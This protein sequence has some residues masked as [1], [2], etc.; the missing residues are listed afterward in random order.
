MLETVMMLIRAWAEELEA[1]SSFAMDPAALFWMERFHSK[2][3]KYH[4]PEVRQEGKPYVYGTRALKNIPSSI[5]SP[6][7]SK[8]T[9]SSSV[10]S[11]STSN[12]SNGQEETLLGKNIQSFVSEMLGLKELLLQTSDISELADDDHAIHLLVQARLAL[13]KLTNLG[14]KDTNCKSAELQSLEATLLE[15]LEIFDN[16]RKGPKKP[17]KE[18]IPAAE[19][20][21]SSTSF[22]SKNTQPSPKSWTREDISPQ[23]SEMPTDLDDLLSLG[24]S[25]E[26]SG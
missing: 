1:S 25:S 24:L 17:V 15:V 3:L 13:K 19:T 9:Y 6:I 21:K 20:P 10:Q 22:Q 18:E 11:G 7:V 2:N 16:K 23:T 12:T 14:T 5:L 8:K 26:N 4:F